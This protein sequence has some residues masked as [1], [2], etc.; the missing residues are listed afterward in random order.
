MPLNHDAAGAKSKPG[1][2]SWDSKDALLYAIGVGAGT[3]ELAFTTENTKGVD[4]Q[5]LPTM[6]VVLGV[7][8]AGAWDALGDSREGRDAARGVA[9]DRP[10]P[11]PEQ[12]DE[13]EVERST[14]HGT[15]NAGVGER[16]GDVMPVQAVS[17]ED[18]LRSEERDQRRRKSEHQGDDAEHARLCPEHGESLGTAANVELIMPVEY[19]PLITSTPST[20][21]A[22]CATVTPIKLVS[23]G[24]KGLDPRGSSCSSGSR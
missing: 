6:G 8:G 19:S 11:E 4:Q 14:D 20:P 16:Q 15:R 12:P 17:P 7:S 1:E 13:G 10:E 3:D 21:I 18:R 23:R 9:E 22:S 5:V 24:L 2:R